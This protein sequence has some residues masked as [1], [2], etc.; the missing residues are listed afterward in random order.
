MADA[1]N[2]V[3]VV[4]KDNDY[5]LY[6]G[7]TELSDTLLIIKAS[8]YDYPPQHQMKAFKREAMWGEKLSNRILPFT[9]CDEKVF[10]R[11]PYLYVNNLPIEPLI[12]YVQ[13]SPLDIHHFLQLA[14]EITE[15][16]SELH[17]MN[18]IHQRINPRTILINQSTNRVIFSDFRFS[19]YFTES[20][21]KEQIQLLIQSSMPYISPEQTGRIGR[22]ID[23]RTDFYSLG[24]VFYQ[25]LT[26]ILPLQAKDQLEWIYSHIAKQVQ[27]PHIIK[28]SIPTEISQIVMKLLAKNP[29]ERYQ[30][31]FGL[32][33]DLLIIQEQ[34]KEEGTITE[35]SLGKFDKA[36][37]INFSEIPLIGREKQRDIINSI[38]V[39]VKKENS[40]EKILIY[41][42]TGVGKSRLITSFFTK[43][44]DSDYYF[45]SCI[46][47]KT[48]R[49]VP[50]KPFI[51]AF[52][53][54]IH[55]ILASGSNAVEYWKEKLQTTLGKNAVIISE[56]IPDLKLII[57]ECE[58]IEELSFYETENRF[59][60][61]FKKF[62]NIF[63]KENVPLILFFDNI[64]WVD[65][66][67]L[68]FLEDLV[69]S[70]VYNNILIIGATR[71]QSLEK[72]R[73]LSQFFSNA[74]KIKLPPFNED[75]VSEWVRAV[76]KAQI[77]NET[78]FTEL[79]YQ[80]TLGTPFYLEQIFKTIYDQRIIYYDY[81]NEGWIWDQKR[82][83]DIPSGSNVIEFIKQKIAI[84]SSRFNET[85]QIASCIGVQFD[86]IRLREL[87]HFSEEE[88]S[89]YLSIAVKEGLIEKAKHFHEDTH[90]YKF[91]HNEIWKIFYYAIPEERK[92][93]TKYKIG[94]AMLNELESNAIEQ[95][96]YEVIS[97]INN[98]LDIETEQLKR[99]YYSQLNSEAARKAK[100]S[101]AYELARFYFDFALK[102]LA[103]DEWK[104][105][106]YTFYLHYE[107]IE[108]MFLSGDHN[109]ANE[110]VEWLL[111]KCQNGT[112]RAKVLHLKMKIINHLREPKKVMDI[113]IEA[114]KNVQFY[115]PNKV[116]F[117]NVLLEYIKLKKRLK[118]LNA[119]FY[120]QSPLTEESELFYNILETLGPPAYLCD[121]KFYGYYIVKMVNIHLQHKNHPSFAHALMQ[122]A[123]F[124]IFGLKQ[125]KEGYKIAQ[126]SLELAEKTGMDR[127]IGPVYFCYGAYTSHFGDDLEKSI[128]YLKKAVKHN[129]DVGN[130]TVAGGSLANYLN[131]RIKIG[132]HLAEIEQFVED[133]LQV[134]LEF[135]DEIFNNYYDFI[136]AVITLFRREDLP[137]QQYVEIGELIK[138][139]YKKGNKNNNVSPFFNAI[140]LI[141][142]YYFQ[143]YEDVF[144]IGKQLFADKKKYTLIGGFFSEICVFHTLIIC[145]LSPSDRQDGIAIMRYY[146]KQLKK[147]VTISPENFMHC[148]QLVEASWHEWHGNFKKAETLYEQA[149]LTVEEKA[150]LFYQAL[151]CECLA[152]LYKNE[153]KV[154][155]YKK[156][157][158]EAYSLYKQWGANGIAQMLVKTNE[159]LCQTNKDQ[160]H[161]L[162][163]STVDEMSLIKALQILSKELVL[164]NVLK[165]IMEIVIKNAA[166]ERGVF[167]FEQ[168]DAPYIKIEVYGDRPDQTKIEFYH[169]SSL[170]GLPLSLIQ[171]VKKVKKY[172][173]ANNLSVGGRFCDDP[174]VLQYK[175]KSVLC[176]PILNKGQLVGILYLENNLFESAFTKSHVNILELLSTQAVISIENAL[177]YKKMQ[178]LNDQLEEKVKERT[179]YLEQSQKEKAAALLEK[180]I[181]EE[182]NRIAREIHDVV[183]HTLTSSLVQIEASKRLFQRD[184]KLALEKIDVVQQ[185]IRKGLDDI[186]RSVRMLK[187]EDTF[188][189]IEEVEQLIED[190]MSFANVNIEAYIDPNLPNLPFSIEKVLYH[191][192]QEGLTNGIKH[193]KSQ[194]FLFSIRHEKDHIL[195]ALKDDGTGCD[196]L[197][198]GFGLNSMKERVEEINGQ[199]TVDSS[200]GQGT[201][202]TIHIPLV[203]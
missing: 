200:V 181:L 62:I 87:L 48:E 154:L 142:C 65:D 197:K 8:V 113:G 63:K 144:E 202:I 106:D 141:Y 194:S 101:I 86:G 58:P 188:Y 83:M 110:E 11:K 147:W 193:G 5:I 88:F 201:L 79:L 10:N 26:G 17:H 114:L 111:D 174:Y 64:Q 179:E 190:T 90:Y 81:E 117:M 169:S 192:L 156:F 115:F 153:K 12:N 138:Q 27:P 35:F 189:F 122:Y 32:L 78:T 129:L 171:Y 105:L 107:R 34:L 183:G 109:Y 182:R 185:L 164:K 98:G 136:S 139:L 43:E 149:L 1:T 39:R 173:L 203:E 30:T 145:K 66:A 33:N 29:E 92:I 125:Y 126:I 23:Y 152:N 38:F 178:E 195:F 103:E 99:K 199:L 97:F 49:N 94:I 46:C 118:E 71:D 15:A 7:F 158:D 16:L 132:G 13:T 186:R 157:I 76:L 167:L 124:L 160:E 19:T 59:R 93:E 74:T 172:F 177:L 137:Y 60:T 3:E 175:P 131:Y 163:P 159:Y 80:K 14:I 56:V 61:V 75:E 18:V 53:E 2:I 21:P 146:R 37:E 40:V 77:E 133:D 82:M 47:L 135:R 73:Q 112:Q 67:T 91:I 198:F 50:Y 134:I 187:S 108:C 54:I 116:K 84:F 70:N 168:D 24:V 36:T 85:L 52:T 123:L 42:D 69:Q 148:Y 95:N 51:Q 4:C 176:L 130:F 44:N 119:T 196:S 128:F 127:V 166:A 184:A 28:P 41:G 20:L 104:D 151:I 9:L 57:G 68:A 72:R 55:K 100:K 96:L 89:Q 191:A 25:L 161:F 45:L 140:Y 120:I 170:Q 102:W 22:K 31:A 165:K 150:N 6:K 155:L 162:L 143:S 180:S 121:Q